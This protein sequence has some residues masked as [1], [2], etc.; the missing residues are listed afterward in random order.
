MGRKQKEQAYI[1]EDGLQLLIFLFRI[2]VTPI[3]NVGSKNH[4]FY[5]RTSKFFSVP[6]IYSESA[7]SGVRISIPK[8]LIDGLHIL[9][10]IR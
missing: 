5:V 8:Q 9:V 1:A 4:M 7:S 6:L 3:S 2:P 10:Y